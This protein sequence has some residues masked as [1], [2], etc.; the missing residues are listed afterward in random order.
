MTLSNSQSTALGITGITFTG[1]NGG[2]NTYTGGTTVS[3]GTLLASVSASAL[4]AGTLTMSGGKLQL[5]DNSSL[6]FGRNTTVTVN[7]EIDSA[8]FADSGAGSTHSSTRSLAIRA[9]S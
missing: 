2:A 4:G 8:R 6:N 3:N 1:T 9:A 7:S 5:A